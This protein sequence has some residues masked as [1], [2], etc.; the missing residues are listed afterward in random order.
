MI[1]KYIIVGLR[2]IHPCYVYDSMVPGYLCK[3]TENHRQGFQ[4]YEGVWFAFTT[5]PIHAIHFETEADAM[6]IVEALVK[7]DPGWF[8]PLTVLTMYT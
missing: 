1:K 2:A 3:A 4:L 5:D 7:A 8:R 6:V